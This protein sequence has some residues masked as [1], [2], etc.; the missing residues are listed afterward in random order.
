MIPAID[1][2]FLLDT[3]AGTWSTDRKHWVLNDS[4][5]VLKRFTGTDGIS[6]KDNPFNTSDA[7]STVTH[8]GLTVD[9]VDPVSF[10]DSDTLTDSVE[11]LVQPPA[12]YGRMA[13]DDIGGNSGTTLNYSIASRVLGWQ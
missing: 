10:T 8:F 13:L 3:R 5:A 2:E 12:R 11:F 9:G 6:R 1:N 7:N 4:A